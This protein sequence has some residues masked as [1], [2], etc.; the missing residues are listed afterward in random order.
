MLIKT[1]HED[2][3]MTGLKGYQ[4][5]SNH[6]AMRCILSKWIISEVLHIV[7]SSCYMVIEAKVNLINL[8]LLVRL[9]C[10]LC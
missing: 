10:E 8:L 6:L 5:H 2:G 7:S 4:N 9:R 1:M 3:A